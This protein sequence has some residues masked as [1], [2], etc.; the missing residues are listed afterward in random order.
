MFQDSMKYYRLRIRRHRHRHRDM[1]CLRHH[2]LQLDTVQYTMLALDL[3]M[4][5]LDWQLKKIL[6]I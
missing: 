4:E 3:V 2:Q 1:N 6:D 5:V